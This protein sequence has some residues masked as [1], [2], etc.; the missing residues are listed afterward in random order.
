M[1]Y[2]EIFYIVHIDTKEHAMTLTFKL[3]RVEK[4]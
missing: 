3:D 1:A 2:K 4:N